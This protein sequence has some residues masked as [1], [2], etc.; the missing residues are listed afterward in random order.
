MNND[1]SSSPTSFLNALV[2]ANNAT[3]TAAT[4]SAIKT[5]IIPLS[6]TQQVINLNLTNT[7]YMFW[8]M[9]MKSYL[10]GQGVFSFVDGSTVCPSSHNDV[11]A[12]KIANNSGFSQAFLAW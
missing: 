1:N 8:R 3:M 4:V 7:N 5:M 2:S 11:S 12:T 6:N 10:I 9:Q